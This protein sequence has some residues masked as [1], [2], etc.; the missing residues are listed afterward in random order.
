MARAVASHILVST[1]QEALDLKTQI[2]GGTAF[3]RESQKH[4]SRGAAVQRKLGPFVD[5]VAERLRL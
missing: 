2:E 4:H 5:V 3:S 1:E